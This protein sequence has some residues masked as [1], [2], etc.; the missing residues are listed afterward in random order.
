MLAAMLF[1]AMSSV[2]HSHIVLQ[3]NN[4][5]SAL[6]TLKLQ[7][8]GSLMQRA[9]SLEKTL[10]L[11]KVEGRRRGRQRMRWL[12]G[13]TDSMDM[14]L[15]K[16]REIVKDRE[17]W[18]AAVHGVTKSQTWLSNWTTTDGAAL[19]RLPGHVGDPRGAQMP[20]QPGAMTSTLGLLLTL[21]GHIHFPPGCTR[22]MLTK[23]LGLPCQLQ[24]RKA[25]THGLCMRVYVCSATQSCPTLYDATDCSPP[26]SSVHGLCAH[27]ANIALWLN[28]F[29]HSFIHASI[30]CLLHARDRFLLIE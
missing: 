21:L 2:P 27:E 24:E 26:G 18:S 29:S 10:M 25:D 3:G 15:S 14:S 7:Y 19:G 28:S 20:S 1:W 6:E 30:E 4:G 11:G 8:F 17:A 23:G 9:D 22:P 12:D 16:P 5:T 13:V